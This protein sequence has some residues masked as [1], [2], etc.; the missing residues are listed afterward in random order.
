M[1]DYYRRNIA[2]I[3]IDH[4]KGILCARFPF[5]QVVI[6]EIKARIP[7]GKKEWSPQDGVWHFSVEVAEEITDILFRNF[8]DVI[9]LTKEATPV[10]VVT[11]DSLLAILPKEDQ[12]EI[13]RMLAKKYHPDRN[14]NGHQM[15]AK[16]NTIFKEV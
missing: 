7:K 9:D 11:K 15:M 3:W 6:D 5:N 10:T 4:S 13:Y 12:K 2:K 8:A 16:I 14:P 1:R